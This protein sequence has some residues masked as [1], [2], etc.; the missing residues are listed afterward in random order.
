MPS[1]TASVATEDESKPELLKT[2]PSGAFRV[3]GN[4]D[5][6]WIAAGPVSGPIH[7]AFSAADNAIVDAFHAAALAAGGRDNGAPGERDY[8][9]GYYAAYVL[10]PD[11]NNVE[12]VFH[13]ATQS[14][15]KLTFSGSLTEGSAATPS[16]VDGNYSLTVF[17]GLV[18]G[19]VQGGQGHPAIRQEPRR[20]A[21]RRRVGALSRVE[22]APQIPRG[23]VVRRRHRRAPDQD[24][25]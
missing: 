9:P 22:N 11:G 10:D 7:V 6:F 17:S 5:D 18:Q 24:G 3:I 1:A 4:G 20:G 16:L 19:G 15:A 8:H 2:S 23:Q 14:V 13:T 21:G 25:R 12:A